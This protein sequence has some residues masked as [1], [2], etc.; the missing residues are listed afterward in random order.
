MPSAE[1]RDINVRQREEAPLSI[2]ALERRSK[3][4]AFHLYSRFCSE[5]Y[6]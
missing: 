3:V 4:A 2:R 6:F 1:S 5:I